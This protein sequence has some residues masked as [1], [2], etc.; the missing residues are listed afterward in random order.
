M[1]HTAL[2]GRAASI[3]TAAICAVSLLGA[4]LLLTWASG[5]ASAAPLVGKDGKV[6][7]CY[8]VKGKAKGTLRVVRG[9]KVKC[10]KRWKKVAWN[11]SGPAGAPGAAGATG[12]GGEPGA[13]GETGSPGKNENAVVTELESKV[14]ELTTKVSGLT[15]E[16]SAL[17]TKVG[18]LESILAG[19]TSAQLQSAVAAVPAV[20]SLCTQTKELNEQ[21]TALGSSLSGL[22][23]VVDTLTI[24][25]IPTMPTALPPFSCPSF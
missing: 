7:A 22:A 16:V 2:Q 5:P 13:K 24:L 1:G 11:A 8:K 17:T 12:A 19:V 21:T 25:A 14:S 20:E 6:H 15:T 23:T 10:P 4:V 9:A 18:S 3:R